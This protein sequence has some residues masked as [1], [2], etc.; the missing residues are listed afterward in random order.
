MPQ[1]GWYPSPEDPAKLAF[2]DGAQWTG[3]T[4]DRPSEQPA[5]PVSR[6]ALRERR[7]EGASMAL[8]QWGFPQAP[9]A[10]NVAPAEQPKDAVQEQSPVADAGD[11]DDLYAALEITPEEPTAAAS[12]SDAQAVY[13]PEPELPGTSFEDYS[14]GVKEGWSSDAQAVYDA[15]QTAFRTEVTEAYPAVATEAPSYPEVYEPVPTQSPVYPEALAPYP[16]VSEPVST[17]ASQPLPAF[18]MPR[19]SMDDSALVDTSVW[20]SAPI[21]T[22]EPA[23]V[24]PSDENDEFDTVLGVKPLKKFSRSKKEKAAPR[25][26]EPLLERNK[27]APA[28]K[29]P[30]P[31]RE[32]KTDSLF[33]LAGI[34]SGLVT[35]AVGLVVALGSLTAVPMLLDPTPAGGAVQEGEQRATAQ[36]RELNVDID[37]YCHPTVEVPTGLGSFEV[38]SLKLPEL[39]TACPVK[40]GESVTVYFEPNSGADAR[41]VRAGVVPVDLIMWSAFGIG[42]LVAAWGALRTWCVWKRVRIPLVTP[43]SDEPATLV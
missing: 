29:S 10:D 32:K 4:M 18:E 11:V 13:T 6:R 41:Y 3:Q 34:R 28:P 16:T 7:D 8:P 20:S 30:K 21:V 42:F 19:P 26:S 14:A 23:E 43:K 35:A 9:E 12:Y 33:Q 24:S 22:S 2:W 39:N 36:V 37:G 40:V 27:V 1:P 31:P 25:A 5:Q 15:A 38:L 17:E